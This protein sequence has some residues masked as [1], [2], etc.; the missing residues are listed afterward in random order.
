MWPLGSVELYTLMK[1][2]CVCQL[3]PASLSLIQLYKH[4]KISEISQLQSE[5]FSILVSLTENPFGSPGS[6]AVISHV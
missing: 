3:C 2:K 4:S 1:E 6:V 5:I